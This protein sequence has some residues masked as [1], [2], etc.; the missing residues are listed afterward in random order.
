MKTIPLRPDFY[1]EEVIKHVAT[2]IVKDMFTETDFLTSELVHELNNSVDWDGYRL[3]RDLEENSMWEANSAMVE[4][5]DMAWV[6][7]RRK[8]TSLVKKWAVDFPMVPAIGPGVKVKSRKKDSDGNPIMRV[9]WQYRT[10]SAE[11]LLESVLGV[12]EIYSY[13]ELEE[14]N[15]FHRR[16]SDGKNLWREAVR[17]TVG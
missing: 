1:S 11:Y 12:S 6:L 14:L 8:Y 17:N 4:K 10:D 2:T 15:G 3:A 7:G 5:L 9:T 13:E 16:T